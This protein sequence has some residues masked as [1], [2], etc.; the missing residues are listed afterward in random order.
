MARLRQLGEQRAGKA[1]AGETGGDR[2]ERRMK[3]MGGGEGGSGGECFKVSGTDYPWK[4]I[5]LS[6]D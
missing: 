6:W 5:N 4:A 1:D 2:Q 3:K